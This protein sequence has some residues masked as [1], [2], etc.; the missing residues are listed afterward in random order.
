MMALK[1]RDDIIEYGEK[2]RIMKKMFTENGFRIY[3]KDIDEPVGDGFYLLFHIR[4]CL[5]NIF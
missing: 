2:A 3:E 1:F 4:V 5:V